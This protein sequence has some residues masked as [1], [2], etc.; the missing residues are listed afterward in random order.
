MNN[1][2]TGCAARELHMRGPL[3]GPPR[4]CREY[5]KEASRCTIQ[6]A[7][8]VGL[9]EDVDSLLLEGA[10]QCV[11][12][13]VGTPLGAVA[14]ATLFKQRLEEWFEH[15]L[16]GEFHDLVFEAADPQR[17]L[18]LTARLGNVYPALGL[19]TVSHAFEAGGQSLEVCPPNSRVHP[20]CYLLPPPPL[21]CLYP[22]ITLPPMT[23]GRQSGGRKTPL[24][25]C[26]AC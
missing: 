6:E 11:K 16:G 7:T 17:A 21:L 12:A 1:Y 3:T 26:N 24:H 2:T 8:Y 15:P 22:L 13:L 20:L 9:Y 4:V 19:G 10:S 18:R 14:I 23:P 25:L 5:L